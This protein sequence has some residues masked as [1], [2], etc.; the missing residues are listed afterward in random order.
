MRFYMAVC[1]HTPTNV[2][3]LLTKR[4]EGSMPALKKILAEFPS[5]EWQVVLYNTPMDKPTLYALIQ[6]PTLIDVEE[7]PKT[8][9]VSERGKVSK[10]VEAE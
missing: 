4:A 3:W 1:N 10:K 2:D 7:L 6:D 8:W 9:V 5:T